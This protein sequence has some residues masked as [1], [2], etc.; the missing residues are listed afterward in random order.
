MTQPTTEIRARQAKRYATRDERALLI[1]SNQLLQDLGFILEESNTD[2][3]LL[4]AQKDRTAFDGG[5]VAGTMALGMLFGVAGAIDATTAIDVDQKFRAS[6]V[7][8]PSADGTSTD[9]RVTF[10]RTVWNAFG[11]ITK[12][13]R[14][15]NQEL[16]T[17]FFD[18][19]SKSMF[20]EAQEVG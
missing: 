4:V 13:E 17:E 20:L 8:A 1:A 14:L 2:A 19:L 5:Q 12:L 3:G 6:V 10:Q 7:V 9:V 18:M 15:D 16:Y 11:R